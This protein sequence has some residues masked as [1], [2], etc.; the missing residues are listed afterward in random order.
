MWTY[1]PLALIKNR[2]LNVSHQRDEV[3]ERH[4]D[5][6]LSDVSTVLH[7]AN[8]LVVA[9]HQILEKFAFEVDCWRCKRIWETIT[10]D[11]RGTHLKG[12]YIHFA[13]GVQFMYHKNSCIMSPVGLERAL[14]HFNKITWCH[15]D[16]RGVMAAWTW[17]FVKSAFSGCTVM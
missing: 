2:R 4:L 11:G 15:I 10:S 1:H 16:V 13:N 9:L 14:Q 6:D 8:V 3:G 7:G 5:V 12:H 17:D